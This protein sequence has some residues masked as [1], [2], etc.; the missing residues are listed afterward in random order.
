MRPVTNKTDMIKG[1]FEL[2]QFKHII[3]S[4]W[5]RSNTLFYIHSG[6]RYD[7]E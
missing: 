4:N 1:V 6:P 5:L 3:M 2:G 7:K